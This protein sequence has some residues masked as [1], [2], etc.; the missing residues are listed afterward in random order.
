MTRR[1]RPHTRTRT[2][3]HRIRD[4]LVKSVLKM[5]D[6]LFKQRR[7]II[8][9][10]YD[11][12]KVLGIDLPR[13]QIRIVEM[14]NGEVSGISFVGKNSIVIS[15]EIADWTEQELLRTV[16]HELGHAWFNAS[17]D[18]SCPLMSAYRPP[19]GVPRAKLVPALRRIAAEAGGVQ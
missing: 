17:H 15:H 5:D 12:K 1:D 9:M 14:A 2:R 19:G 10:L 11:A 16:W 6:A 13:V 4:P 3:T 18:E 7:R 8:E